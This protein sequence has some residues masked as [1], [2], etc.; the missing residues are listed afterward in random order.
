MKHP[1]LKIFHSRQRDRPRA[2]LTEFCRIAL[3]QRL[4]QLVVKVIKTRGDRGRHALII[5]LA[6]AI[7]LVLESIVEIEIA[8]PVVYFRRVVELDLRDQQTGEPP[9]VIMRA[10][11]SFAPRN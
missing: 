6:T 3:C 2:I 11:F 8:A 7:D 1:H 10:L 9:R 5:H 4:H